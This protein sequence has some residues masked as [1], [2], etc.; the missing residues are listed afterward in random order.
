MQQFEQLTETSTGL[1]ISSF[2]VK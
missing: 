1:P 2:N